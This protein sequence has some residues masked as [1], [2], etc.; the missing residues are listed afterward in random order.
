M[1]L[2]LGNARISFKCPECGFSNTV[3]LTQVEQSQTIICSGCHKN[4]KL[5]DK[6]GS[7]KRAIEQVNKSIDDLN[8]A[9]DKMNRS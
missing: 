9:I 2:N 4:I 6:D 8:R 5:I 7:T 3:T 1:P